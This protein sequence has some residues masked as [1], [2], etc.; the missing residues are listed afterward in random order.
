MKWTR[1]SPTPIP[2]KPPANIQGTWPESPC[3]QNF[4]F[5]LFRPF[6][7]RQASLFPV[8][9]TYS[10][11]SILS[12]WV[13]NSLNLR[14]FSALSI[15]ISFLLDLSNKYFSSESF[16]ND[17]FTLCHLIPNNSVYALL[18]YTWYGLLY[19]NFISCIGM[20]AL[21]EQGSCFLFPLYSTKSY[22]TLCLIRGSMCRTQSDAQLLEVLEWSRKS[23]WIQQRCDGQS[24]YVL[25]H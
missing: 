1:E 9:C 10:L 17:C 20:W 12:I 15:V 23:F 4:N 19:K 5:H 21:G 11:S 25:D 16:S 3:S 8:T 22:V 14:C 6:Y 24:N 7:F 13:G 2:P 18:F